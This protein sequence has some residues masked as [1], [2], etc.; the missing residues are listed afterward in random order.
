MDFENKINEI[1]DKEEQ[2]NLANTVRFS[3]MKD[4]TDNNLLHTFSHNLNDKDVF[5]NL[6]LIENR[7]TNLEKGLDKKTGWYKQ[8][9]G[10]F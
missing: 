7:L 6:F 2:D 8:L 10:G 4:N 5:N 1:K 3:E 9:Y